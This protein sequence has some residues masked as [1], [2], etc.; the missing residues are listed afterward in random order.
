MLITPDVILSPFSIQQHYKDKLM[1]KAA[2]YQLITV[3]LLASTLNIGNTCAA[4]AP[5]TSSFINDIPALHSTTLLD[6][7][8]LWEAS[9]T[10]PSEYDRFVIEAI[11]IF[12]HPESDYQ[13]IDPVEFLTITD[14][15]RIHLIDALEPR[16]P[17]VN[18]PGPGIALVRIAITG[19][20]LKKRGDLI[21]DP[22]YRKTIYGS[23]INR[24]RTPVVQLGD[25]SMEMEVLDSLTGKRIA[26]AIDPSAVRHGTEIPNWDSMNDAFKLHASRLR[27]RMDDEHKK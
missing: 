16:Y 5:T 19:V 22:F 25:A 11:E 8:Y 26:V 15:L 10:A 9:D 1:P 27:Q 3:G 14:A 2:I 20:K 12:I 23:A 4:D 21:T 17:V 6:G 13:G 7:L 24:A 18:K